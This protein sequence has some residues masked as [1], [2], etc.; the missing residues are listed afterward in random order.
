MLGNI[1]DHR[2]RPHRWKCVNVVVEATWLDNRVKDSDQALRGDH[3]YGDR[4][5]ISLN[6]AIAWANTFEELV[7]L[8]I[9][10]APSVVEGPAIHT[11]EAPLVRLA[12]EIF[13]R[14]AEIASFRRKF[15]MR[16]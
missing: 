3:T 2:K 12:K 4:D 15:G 6:E 11:P 10:D 16:A 13:A 8:Y 5:W 7:T 1:C 14:M 9:Y